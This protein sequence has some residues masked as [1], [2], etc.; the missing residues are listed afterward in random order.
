ME[1]VCDERSQ[2]ITM[3]YHRWSQTFSVL[4]EMD[5]MTLKPYKPS[6]TRLDVSE[7]LWSSFEVRT[8]KPGELVHGQDLLGLTNPDWR[9]CTESCC[10]FEFYRK[11]ASRSPKKVGLR[12]RFWK[13]SAESAGQHWGY[14]VTSTHRYTHKHKHKHILVL[15]SLWGLIDIKHCLDSYPNNPN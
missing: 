6:Y 3:Y 1:L 9:V 11:V 7:Y 14:S 8:W 2:H 10:G 15:L 13:K 5:F 4:F 12:S